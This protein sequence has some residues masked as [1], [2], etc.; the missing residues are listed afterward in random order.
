MSDKECAFCTLTEIQSRKITENKLAWAFPTN[1]PIVPGHTLVCPKRCVESFDQLTDEEL[2]SL[3]ALL[4]DIKTALSTAFEASG[5]N[6]AWNEGSLAG[7]SVPHLHLHVLP[8]KDG[9][10][11]LEEYDPRS[12]LYRTGDREPTP[13]EELK[14]VA[15]LISQHL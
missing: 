11:G 1:I 3:F 6:Y 14:K 4:R 10:S 15:T 12:H 5:F 7:Q 2:I 13:E 9:D 8:R